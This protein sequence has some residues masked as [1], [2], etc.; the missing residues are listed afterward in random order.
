[1]SEGRGTTKPFEL[2]GA[3]WIDGDR[4]AAAMNGRGLPGARF[5][6][7]NFEPTFHK[8]AKTPCGGCQLHVTDRTTFQPVEAGV[9][10]LEAFRDASPKKF[11]WR[12]PPYEYEATKAPI[13]ILYGSGQLREAFDRGTRADEIAAAWPAELEPFL[14]LRE[15][16][17][18]Y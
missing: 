1:M 4:F 10:L 8:H 18:L 3:P 5:R 13:D 12:D 14:D 2:I 6:G 11:A 17:L 7:V 16:F 15:Q 9:A